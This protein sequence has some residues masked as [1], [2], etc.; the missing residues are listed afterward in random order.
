MTR[1]LNAIV[2]WPDLNTS[3]ETWSNAELRGVAINRV[4]TG[5]GRHLRS[6]SDE[7]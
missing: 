6:I 7:D 2:R 3:P 5:I 1:K 4:A